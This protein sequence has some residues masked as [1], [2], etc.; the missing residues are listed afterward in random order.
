MSSRAKR[1]QK[2]KERD[3]RNKQNENRDAEP[4][5]NLEKAAKR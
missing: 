4:V 1:K 5:V 3:A 2:V